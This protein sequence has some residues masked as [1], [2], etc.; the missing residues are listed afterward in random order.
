M[1][2]FG[3]MALLLGIA[4]GSGINLYATVF[5]VGILDATESVSL[6]PD[7]QVLSHPFVLGAS[8]F[9]FVMEFFADK[10]P[11]LDSIW[12]AIHTFIR[13]PAGTLLSI[14]AA[15]SVNPA[16]MFAAGLAG[17]GITAGTHFTKAGSRLLINS[18]PEPFSNWIASLGSDILVFTIVWMAFYHPIILFLLFFL[19]LLL[20]VLTLPLI[21]MLFSSIKTLFLLPAKLFGFVKH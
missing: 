8:G 9:L 13:I 11:G 6:P 2:S 15:N 1:E 14:G 19:F 12:D 7:L 3:T 17:G 16:I 10:V 4:W 21:F 20:L 18:S 5:L